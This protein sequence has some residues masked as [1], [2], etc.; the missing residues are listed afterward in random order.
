[1][2]VRT[3]PGEPDIKPRYKTNLEK[4][5]D[6]PGLK[7][8][9]VLDHSIQS[10]TTALPL[11][12]PGIQLLYFRTDDSFATALG[13]GQCNLG[14]RMMITVIFF[15]YMGNNFASGCFHFRHAWPLAVIGKSAKSLYVL[16][17]YFTDACQE[18]FPFSPFAHFLYHIV[19]SLPVKLC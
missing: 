1:M 19:C 16:F 13:I 12:T 17:I 9:E 14:W 6:L 11:I 18:F 8:P 4:A 7:R 3:V 15:C 2:Y 10:L 5:V